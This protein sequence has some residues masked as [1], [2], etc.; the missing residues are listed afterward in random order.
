MIIQKDLTAGRDPVQT[1]L[2]ADMVTFS[3][4]NDNDLE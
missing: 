3:A 4:T 1:L 2:L